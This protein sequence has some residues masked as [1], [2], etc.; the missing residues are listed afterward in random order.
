MN[1][2]RIQINPLDTFFFRDGRPFHQGETT[3]IDIKSM[4]PPSPTTLVGAL[5]AAWARS[6]GWNGKDKWDDT[7]K[8]KLGDR[9]DLGDLQ[10][11][12]PI[13]YYDEKPVFPVPYSIVGKIARAGKEESVTSVC[14]LT[15]GSPL[16]CDIDPAH[17]VR[18]PY[19]TD[20]E[21]GLKTLDG[22]WITKSELSKYLNGNGIDKD[23][24]IVPEKLIPSKKLWKTEVRIGIQRNPDTRTTEE[25]ALYSPH[26]IRLQPKTQLCMFAS[27]IPKDEVSSVIPL[28]G[29]SRAC[30]ISFDDK[31]IEFK[32][33]LPELKEMDGRI[34]YTVMVLTPLKMDQPPQPNQSLLDLPGKLVSAC[35]P[36]SIRLGGWKNIGNEKSPKPLTPFIAPGSV[37]FMEASVSEKE[38]IKSFHGKTIGQ[39][40]AWGFGLIAIGQWKEGEQA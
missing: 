15:P 1:W 35:M 19:L 2:Q 29:E 11:I 33:E 37:F 12:G 4:F 5:R 27:K 36:R 31:N 10:F 38:Q 25:G 14:N 13:L 8:A 21:A 18:L 32:P 6:M 28:G 22:W 24:G 17:D 23:T 9:E 34:R 3:Q 40:S 39:T 30:R 26:H 16:R 7:I 20:G